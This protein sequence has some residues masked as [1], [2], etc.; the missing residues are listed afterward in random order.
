MSSAAAEPEPDSA[1]FEPW[2]MGAPK[3]AQATSS[4][5]TVGLPRFP[6]VADG[7]DGSEGKHGYCTA[8]ID[9]FL[10]TARSVAPRTCGL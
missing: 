9:D 1:S 8:L 4:S 10:A 2:R 6:R 3:L 7:H 5:D